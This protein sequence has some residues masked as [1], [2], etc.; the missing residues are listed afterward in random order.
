MP[1]IPI[2]RIPAPEAATVRWGLGE[3]IILA[4]LFTLPSAAV[5]GGSLYWLLS[6]IML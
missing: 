5:L 6:V 3:K 2:L 4:W 1:Q